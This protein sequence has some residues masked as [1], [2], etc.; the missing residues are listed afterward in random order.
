MSV[1]EAPGARL[2]YEVCGEGP[3]L[4]VEPAAKGEAYIYRDVADKLSTRYQVATY[5]RRGF[6]R[7]K[8]DGAQDYDRRLGTDANDVRRLIKRLSDERAT[9]SATVRVPLWR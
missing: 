2:Y 6:S 8:L 5:D 7:S 3:L 1:L 4:V 9:V